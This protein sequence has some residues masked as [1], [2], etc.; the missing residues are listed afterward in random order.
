MLMRRRSVELSAF[1][2]GPSQ[3]FSSSKGEQF[4]TCC[5]PLIGYLVGAAPLSCLLPSVDCY[6]D[7][8]ISAEAV[9]NLLSAFDWLLGGRSSFELSAISR[10]L[11][12]K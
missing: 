1:N 5:Q 8:L 12:R 2:H 9:S 6:R 4:Q 10:L 7:F 3:G 11:H